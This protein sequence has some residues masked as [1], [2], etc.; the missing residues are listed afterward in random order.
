MEL[1]NRKLLPWLLQ[2]NGG[3]H[4]TLGCCRRCPS[5]SGTRKGTPKVV[6]LDIQLTNLRES[7]RSPLPL[8]I[9]ARDLAGAERLAEAGFASLVRDAEVDE[10]RPDVA[11]PEPVLYVGNVPPCVR[12]MDAD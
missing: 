10:S 8:P 1:F 12:E 2:Y 9:R 6:I 4:Q 3:P 5:S 11:V 7:V